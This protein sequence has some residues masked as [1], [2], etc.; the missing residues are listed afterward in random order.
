[1]NKKALETIKKYNML[2][3]GD[4]VVCAVSGGADSMALLCFLLEIKD[5]FE[6]KLA[7]CHV[8]HLLREGEADRDETFV[9]N[10]CNKKGV[11]FH[12]LRAD[13]SAISREKGLGF[14]ECGRLVRYEFL[15]DT[16]KKLGGAKIATAH[17]LSDCA[18][19]LIFNIARGCSPA[20][21]SSI[22]PIRDNVIRP[23]IECTRSEIEAYLLSLSQ[24]YVTDSTNLSTE[25][26]R[27]YIRKE[28]IPNLYKLNPSFN[29]SVLNLTSLSREQ[30]DFFKEYSKKVLEEIR[31]NNKIS[32]SEF[33]KL[34]IAVKRGIISEV[35]REN[36]I[37]FS[38]KRCDEILAALKN[39]DFKISVCK[40]G[41][42]TSKGGYF[43][44]EKDKTGENTDFEFPVLLGKTLLPDLCELKLSLI[45]REE[46]EKIKKTSPHLLKNCLSY[47]IIDSSFVIRNRK[48]GDFISLFPRNVTK[49]LKKLFNESKI[50]ADKRDII[51]LIACNSQVF[52][53][54]GLG[55]DCAAAVT[56]STRR[57]LFI[58]AN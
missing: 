2:T 55:V 46:F 29:S 35:F 26:T 21:V 48:E 12:L 40:G 32:I 28:I 30:A 34:H 56:E 37:E 3:R 11:D 6:L 51:P 27:N 38:K 33:L 24:S 45:S 9:K 17:T 8:N 15:N 25:Y 14:E 20:G 5:E 50:P 49:T 44:F 18:E 36:N 13:V 7:V 19:T 58:E 1:M 47:D 16:A 4:R 42:I 31:E 22:A 52:W 39:G 23:L 57:I 54:M 10:F 41:Y 53:V 43:Y